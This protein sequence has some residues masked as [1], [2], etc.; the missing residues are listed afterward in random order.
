MLCLCVLLKLLI[1]ISGGGK[2]VLAGGLTVKGV[3]VIA[4]KFIFKATMGSL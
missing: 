3:M 4:Q 1:S 2:S